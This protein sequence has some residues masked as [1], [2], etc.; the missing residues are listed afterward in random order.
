MVIFDVNTMKLG[1]IIKPF[2]MSGTV[3]DI[4]YDVIAKPEYSSDTHNPQFDET[5][6]PDIG[7]IVY[8]F[9]GVPCKIGFVFVYFPNI[10]YGSP[11][12]KEYVDF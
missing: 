1:K 10:E 4:D 3:D 2:I 7:D 5:Y 6:Q 9:D 12:L 11:I 8:I